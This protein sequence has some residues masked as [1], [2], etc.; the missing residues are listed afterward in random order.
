M[1]VKYWERWKIQVKK[2]RFFP[3]A[4]W[5]LVA[6]WLAVAPVAFAAETEPEMAGA[7]ATAPMPNAEN[8][9]DRNAP[10][11]RQLE[12]VL[13]EACRYGQTVDI[14]QYDVTED[15]LSALYYTLRG[16]GRFP[17]YATGTYSYSYRQ[18]PGGHQVQS[19]TPELLG[20]GFD[21]MAYEIALQELLQDCQLEGKTPLQQALI[22]HDQLALRCV[23]D[24][25]LVKNTGYQLLVEGS[26]VCAGYAEL[27][28]DILQRLGIPCRVVSSEPMNHAWNLVQLDGNWYH[29]DVTWDDPTPDVVGRVRHIYFL[30]TDSE[31][32]NAES[33]HYD[34]DTDI[35][36]TDSTYVDAFWTEATGQILFTDSNTCYYVENAENL[37]SIQKRD[38]ETGKE[39][40]IY[41]EADNFQ[42]IGAGR[43]RYY[44]SGFAFRDGRLWVATMDQILSMDLDGK[45]KKTEFT[46]DCE[47]NQRYI[48]AFRVT[49]SEL[50]LALGNQEQE[51]ILTAEPL[52]PSHVHSYQK[53]VVAPTCAEE[54]YTL[55]VCE[56][57]IEAKGDVQAP[58][59]H[60]WVEHDGK[61]E[62]FFSD[63]FSDR[64]CTVC[65]KT[66]Y[67]EMAQIDFMAWLKKNWHYV[68]VGICVVVLV[69]NFI[70]LFTPGK[71][72]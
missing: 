70:A 42:D 24:E 47:K 59:E 45:H 48:Q 37:L 6:V 2:C 1:V 33:R 7:S 60:T 38:L 41:Q 11:I 14:A 28:Q 67:V 62:S 23:Y 9:P 39:K 3:A 56:C 44:H 5:L 13:V 20:E 65:G 10:R 26:T 46:Y 66:E 61:R 19:F 35:R 30:K 31:M 25:T 49:D 27:Y 36:C 55:A 54:G 8:L 69:P 29:V 17:W 53:I 57:G 18:Y 16:E 50:V 12:A 21:R 4:V 72:K 43:K 22:V 51:A 58:L 15:Q 68:A 52:T 32:E 64:E 63:G 34:W 71:K 40:Q